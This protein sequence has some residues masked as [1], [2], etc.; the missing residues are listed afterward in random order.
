MT[1]FYRI[2]L[3]SLVLLLGIAV[4][5]FAGYV[6]AGTE[7]VPLEL[8]DVLPVVRVQVN[9]KEYRFLVDTGA[10]SMLNFKTFSAEKRIPVEISSWTGSTFTSA[11]EVVIPEL[12]VGSIKLKGLKLP[13]IDLSLIA[14]ACGGPI[15]GIMGIDLLKRIGAELDLSRSR[16]V[17]KIGE[18]G[19]SPKHF[20]EMEVQKD[21]CV[22]A[23]NR[24]DIEEVRKC[25]D[26]EVFLYSSGQE[27]R[28]RDQFIQYLT[29][30]YFSTD[31]PADLNLHL[32]DY[33][34][35][36]NAI[37]FGYD[38][39]IISPKGEMLMQGMAVCRK[40]GYRWLLLN[41]HNFFESTQ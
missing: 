36:G 33:R 8:C 11:H 25:F 31:P 37:W 13:A 15:D 2:Q 1:W 26:P 38:L 22:S 27:I 5:F 6:R 16:A 10:T 21:H 18:A 29:E 3:R 12:R 20:E 35:V 4:P 41:M 40:D 7:V 28:G 14:E 39:R 30:R 34:S 24:A 23:F 17:L 32:K 19:A 9:G